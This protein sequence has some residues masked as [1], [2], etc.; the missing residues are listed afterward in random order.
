MTTQ[1]NVRVEEKTKKAAMRIFDE[2]GL[3]LSTGVN[4]FLNQVVVDK[5]L[6]FRPSKNPAALVAEWDR[7]VAW[8]RKHGKKYSNVKDL[9]KDLGIK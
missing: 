8:A 4:I 1:I 7:E 6:P 9:M 2:L 5:G 3:D